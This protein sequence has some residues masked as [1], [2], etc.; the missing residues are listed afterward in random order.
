M[1]PCL[2]WMLA[3][4]APCITR[5]NNDD[6]SVGSQS[7]EHHHFHTTISSHKEFARFTVICLM[8]RSHLQIDRD[9]GVSVQLCKGVLSSESFLSKF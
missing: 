4:S 7:R 1:I 3:V 2:L 9:S 5:L 8:R 6:S